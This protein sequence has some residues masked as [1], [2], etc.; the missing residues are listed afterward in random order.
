M[1]T[2]LQG[3][4]YD[5]GGRASLLFPRA[6]EEI[7][8]SY[9]E[10][11]AELIISNT[12]TMNRIY[13]STHETGIDVRDVNLASVKI[14]KQAIDAEGFVLGNISST[15]QM[16]EPY[17]DYSENTFVEC[18]AEQ[19][20]VLSRAGVDGFIVET[21]FDLRE[22]LCALRGCR[23]VS[24]LPVVVG[25]AFTTDENGGR[26]MMG[27]TAEDCVQ[28]L[29][30]A[31]ADAVGANCGDI[32]PSQMANIIHYMREASDLPLLAEPNAGRPKLVNNA[33]VF[34]ME[35]PLFAEGVC[36]CIE[37]GAEL[38]GGCC[39]TSPAHIKALADLISS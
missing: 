26:T 12:L 22:A 14:A 30:E 17:G 13:I 39:G 29:D 21:M 24:E 8:R 3:R 25:M 18:F 11:G 4:G 20:D 23:Q 10:A 36:K 35:P 28:R 19:A 5:G 34:E 16:L 15:G 37:Y 32:D 38:V 33:A 31:G 2:E 1:G 9:V 27:D 6:V 7:H